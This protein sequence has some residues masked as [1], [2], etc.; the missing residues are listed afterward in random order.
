MLGLSSQTAAGKFEE[1]ICHLSATQTF[2][3]VR[4]YLANFDAVEITETMI[5]ETAESRGLAI[6]KAD[7]LAAEKGMYVGTPTRT[8]IL[9]VQADGAMVPIRPQEG[10][11]R[12]E[13]KENK[14][15]IVFREED[16]NRRPD[17]KCEIKK[18]RFATSLAAGVK[19]FEQLLGHAAKKSGSL[20][21]KTIVFISDGSEWLDSVRQRLF[22][23]SVHI[24]DWYHAEEHLWKCAKEI[25]G[26]RATGKINAW[27]VPLKQML[28][29]G[30]AEAVCERLLF[31]AERHKKA[32][33]DLR[34]L[35]GYYHSRV[36]K[37]RYPHFRRLGYFIGSGA[38]ESAHRY[39]VQS[40]LKQAGMK[41]TIPGATAIIKLR[42]KLYEGTWAES[43]GWRAA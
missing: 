15:G 16:L 25:F 34:E 11:K 2:E 29:D 21:A 8:E 18:K 4:G 27:V 35:Y 40:R 26:E 5:R 28:W 23:K 12:V 19:H 22:P 13:Y 1:Q 41:W 7:E 10:A 31:E 9:Y 30:L 36:E 39:L 33:T 38:I 42:E 43:W 20:G 3:L 6:L 32:E 24:L 17:G 14:A 37:M